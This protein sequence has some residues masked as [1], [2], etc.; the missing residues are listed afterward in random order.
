RMTV[1]VHSPELSAG[2][3]YV[4]FGEPGDWLHA[5][6]ELV[7]ASGDKHSCRAIE[8]PFFD[9]EKSILREIPPSASS[10]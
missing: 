7:V 6:L 10:S 9:R 1:G 5:E 4:L 8:L 2:I 3:G